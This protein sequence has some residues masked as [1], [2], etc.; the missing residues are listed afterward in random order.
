[1]R[2][3]RRFWVLAALAALVLLAAVECVARYIGFGNPP[4]ARL[5]GKIEYYL[6]PNRDYS[7][8]GRS[9]RINRLGMRSSDVD[10]KSL[11]R[12]LSVSLFGDSVVYGQMLDQLETVAS[13]LQHRLRRDGLEQLVVN[14][15]AA[16]S[17]G[18]EN[19]L[20]F[21]KRFGPFPG[22]RAWIVQSTHDMI[23]VIDHTQIPYSTSEPLTAIHD[24][25][26]GALRWLNNRLPVQHL[27]TP[28]IAEQRQRADTALAALVHIL[29]ADFDHVELVFH[30]TKDEAV[31]GKAIGE[32]HYQRAAETLD[33][34][35]ASTMKLYADAYRQ[36]T[37]PHYDDIHLSKVGADLLA[38]YLADG[39]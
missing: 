20:E 17:W 39:H 30:A 1:M 38:R 23:D 26:Q 34:K 2:G 31:S 16:S 22:S 14:S 28:T 13:R 9:I 29:K 10:T 27:G 18:S 5:D 11:E 15:V 19:L 3:G 6:V 25:A 35:F 32:Q 4:L 37:P 36:N 21:Y 8:F 7:R 24:L 12:R 33:I